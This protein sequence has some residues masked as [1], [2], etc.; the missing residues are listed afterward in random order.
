[1]LDAA[2]N[3]V[4]RLT[5]TGST[6][7]LERSLAHLPY[8]VRLDIQR[9]LK[10]TREAHRFERAHNCAYY[11]RRQGSRVMIWRWSY[12]ASTGEAARIRTLIQS[13]DGRLDTYRATHIFEKATH[14]TVSRP[15]LAGM[16]FH[17]LDLGAYP[18]LHA[19]GT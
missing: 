10:E 11:L 2:I 13:F 5:I 7:Q 15:R 12:V 9:D 17:A 19:G 8:R 14:R 4:V 16:A 3:K 18:T 1:M 6:W